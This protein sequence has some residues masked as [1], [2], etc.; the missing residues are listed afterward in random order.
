MT[1]LTSASPQGSA[2]HHPALSHTEALKAAHP[3]LRLQQEG[4]TREATERPPQPHLSTRSP[5]P[6]A[7]APQAG[8][9]GAT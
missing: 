8:G 2:S 4:L 3:S 6:Q 1:P 5:G 9:S 7:G